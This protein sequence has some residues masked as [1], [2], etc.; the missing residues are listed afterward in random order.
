VKYALLIA[1][2][3]DLFAYLFDV[4]SRTALFGFAA[5]SV[6]IAGVYAVA[7]EGFWSRRR[8]L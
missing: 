6:I 2:V 5:C 7:T 8:R 1:L 4:I 3:L